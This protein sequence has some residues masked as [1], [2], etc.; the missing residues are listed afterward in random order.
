MEYIKAYIRSYKYP[1][2]VREVAEH[3]EKQ[4]IACYPKKYVAARKLKDGTGTTSPRA[5]QVLIKLTEG[6]DYLARRTQL[7]EEWKRLC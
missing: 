5:S 6:Q 7:L 1:P 2:T 3:Y 4:I